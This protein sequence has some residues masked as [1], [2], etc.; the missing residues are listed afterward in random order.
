MHE[1]QEMKVQ[2]LGR[3]A[4]LEKEMATHSSISPTK[5]HGQRSLASYS[6]QG[7]KESDI[8]H[9][10]VYIPQRHLINH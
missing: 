5:F 9:D 6:P 3:E 2:F 7:R 4:P 10:V 1:M 8:A